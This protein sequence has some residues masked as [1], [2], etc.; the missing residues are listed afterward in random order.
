[1]NSNVYSVT[2]HNDMYVF[3][4]GLKR[5]FRSR[6]QLDCASEIANVFE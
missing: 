3:E 4:E 6:K 2:K 1:M 5:L